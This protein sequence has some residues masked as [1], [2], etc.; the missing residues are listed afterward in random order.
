MIN[1]EPME[2]LVTYRLPKLLGLADLLVSLIS[3]RWCEQA[4]IEP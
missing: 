4:P 2:K 1:A 3:T